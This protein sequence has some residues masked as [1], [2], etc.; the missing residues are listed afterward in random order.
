[1]GCISVACFNAFGCLVVPRLL[2][3]SVG[4]HLFLFVTILKPNK[5]NF[6]LTLKA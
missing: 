6:I 5:N 2:K 4:M 1:M 3:T